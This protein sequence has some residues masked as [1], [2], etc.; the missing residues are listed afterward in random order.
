MTPKTLVGALQGKLVPKE[1]QL[2]NRSYD[3][4]GDIAIL[5]IH[6]SLIK[7]E[8]KIGEAL[9]SMLNH[10]RV[11]CKKVGNHKGVFRLQQLKVIAGEKRK[12][13]EY[14]E[15]NVRLQLNV[16]KCYFSPR[17]STERKRI[18][19]L[20]KKNE[21]ILVMFSGVGPYPCVIAKNSSA[22]SILGIEKNKIAFEYSQKNKEINKLDNVEFKKGDVKTVVPKI[23]KK[24]DRILMPLPKDAGEFLKVALTKSKK[25][26]IIHFYDFQHET[27][28][29]EAKAKV[30]VACK[31]AKKQCKILRLVKC[32]QYSPGKYRVCVDFKIV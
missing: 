3:I 17:L 19:S 9:L 21:N 22:N 12:D 29:D 14:K 18:T 13:T 4:I 31:K 20:V 30:T 1:I 25:G 5:D 6:S 8:K 7:K 28:F 15:N 23:K 2:V 24:F 27:E 16:E 10:I 11:V 26:T 32:G